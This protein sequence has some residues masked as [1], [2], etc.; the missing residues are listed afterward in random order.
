MITIMYKQIITQFSQ[1]AHIKFVGN[2]ISHLQHQLHVCWQ[3]I[4]SSELNLAKQI[5]SFYLLKQK[6]LN[7]LSTCK[8]NSNNMF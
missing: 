2:K 1:R 8:G 6:R 4:I 7:N 3:L 5:L